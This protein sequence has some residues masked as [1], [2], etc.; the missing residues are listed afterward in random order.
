MEVIF[1]PTD[2]TWKLQ[3]DALSRRSLFEMGVLRAI[4]SALIARFGAGR[5]AL[6]VRV[7]F[8]PIEGL[9]YYSGAILRRIRRLISRGSPS[10]E[11]SGAGEEK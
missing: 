7:L 8:H 4:E 2:A 11:H 10:G 5:R 3:G 9:R 1:M 6:L